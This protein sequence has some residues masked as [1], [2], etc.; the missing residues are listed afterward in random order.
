MNLKSLDALAPL[1]V[2]VAGLVLLLSGPGYR[3]NV[4]S[5]PSAFMVLRWGAYAA[6]LGIVLAGAALWRTRGRSVLAAAALVTGLI[7]VAVPLRFY[8]AA[9]AVPPIHDISTDTAT[10]PT[11]NAVVPLR[12]AA[13]NPLAYSQEVARQQRASYPDIKPVILEMPAPQVF[14][15]ALQAARDSGW[16]IVAANADAGRI[17]A[18]DTTFFFGFKDDIVVRVT[19]IGSR[20]IVDVRSVSRVGRSDAGTNA[21]RIRQYL[22]RLAPR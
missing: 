14:E 9:A 19:A 5:L 8:R 1:V 21:R 20:T 7:A 12:A 6:I 18:T 10:P 16:E 4:W 3:L 17:E 11:F 15:R 22:E 2:L 13:P